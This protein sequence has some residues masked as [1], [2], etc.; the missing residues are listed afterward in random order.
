MLR[1]AVDTWMS[2]RGD[3]PTLKCEKQRDLDPFSP[4]SLCLVPMHGSAVMQLDEPTS[5]LNELDKA[6]LEALPV[7]GATKAV[8]AK[9][10]LV[11][12][13]GPAKRP[14]AYKVIGRL[15]ANGHVECDGK[16]YRRLG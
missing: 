6:V 9:A 7:T 15:V 16:V 14:T 11:V 1:A 5:E 3:P 4:I 10:S 8:W 2:L 13:G 12:A